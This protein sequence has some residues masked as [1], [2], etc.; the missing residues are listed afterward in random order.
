MCQLR[1]TGIKDLPS[2]TLNLKPPTYRRTIRIDHVIITPADKHFFKAVLVFFEHF[3]HF[4]Q[5]YP[6][7]DS[8]SACVLEVH[9][10]HHSTFD[11]FDELASDP[12]SALLDKAVADLNPIFGVNQSDTNQMEL[13]VPSAA[14][15][16]PSNLRFRRT[17]T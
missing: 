12:G 15:P 17:P 9:I 5:V 3:S 8:S 14:Y 1:D 2:Q 11:L 13:R 10:K 6:V 16:S 7:R 4:V